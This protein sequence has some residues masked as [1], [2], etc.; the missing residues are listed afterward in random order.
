MLFPDGV[1]IR[2]SKLTD[3]IEFRR[4][5]ATAHAIPLVVGHPGLHDELRA[6]VNST[7]WQVVRKPTCGLVLIL[8]S[9]HN[10]SLVPVL[11]MADEV[12]VSR[13]HPCHREGSICCDG[14]DEGP[15][16]Q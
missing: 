16:S 5:A 4:L 1:G 3:A 2:L 7:N 13:G 10:G 8:L 11:D 9:S 6:E 12:I 14:E 15:H